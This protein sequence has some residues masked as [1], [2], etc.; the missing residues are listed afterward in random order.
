MSVFYVYCSKTHN[1]IGL[2]VTKSL[3][4]AERSFAW[5]K[6]PHYVKLG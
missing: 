5:L 2:V 3:K 6:Q 4:D 1:A